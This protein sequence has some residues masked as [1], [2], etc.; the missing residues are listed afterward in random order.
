M[1][2]KN[3]VVEDKKF[4]L[5]R[6]LRQLLLSVSFAAHPVCRRGGAQHIGPAGLTACAGQSCQLF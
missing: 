3:V 1:V 2:C 4:A 6:Q 5:L